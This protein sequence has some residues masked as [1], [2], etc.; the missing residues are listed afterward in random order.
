MGWSSG[1]GL[2]ADVA[3][4]IADN[5]PDED[6]RRV[7]YKA[8]IEAFEDRDC[9]TLME[10]TGIDETLDEV[11]EEIYGP[12]EDDD[13]DEDDVWPEGGTENFS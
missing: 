8:M 11:L 7:I 12:E 3:E 6:D 4:I 9:D 2:F 13:D 10:C 5:V 1:S